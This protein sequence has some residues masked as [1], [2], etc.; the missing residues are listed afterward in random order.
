MKEDEEEDSDGMSACYFS[1][2]SIYRPDVGEYADYD[3]DFGEVPSAGAVINA[4]P[5]AG[6][7][8]FV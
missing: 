4:D 6:K 2:R 5:Y 8:I 1:S 7:D 3:S